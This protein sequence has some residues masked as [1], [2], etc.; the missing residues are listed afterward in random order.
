MSYVSYLPVSA[1]GNA[2]TATCPSTCVDTF[3]REFP[4]PISS[5]IEM[6]LCRG[7]AQKDEETAI[8][9]VELYVM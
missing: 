6:R 3:H 5:D 1:D 8:G 7:Q 9:N 2:A 4:Q